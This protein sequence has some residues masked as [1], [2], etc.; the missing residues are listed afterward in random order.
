MEGVHQNRSFQRIGDTYVPM[1][2][3]P[4]KFVFITYRKEHI[5]YEE[6]IYNLAQLQDFAYALKFAVNDFYDVDSSIQPFANYGLQDSTVY[7]TPSNMTSYNCY[8]YALGRSSWCS[9][10]E[11]SGHGDMTQT[12]L[13]N[14]SIYELAEYVKDDLQSSTL[15]KKCVKITYTRPCTRNKTTLPWLQFLQYYSYH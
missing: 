6:I 8:A 10:G 9:P 13:K 14:K 3:S 12:T 5:Y 15:N 1:R 7:Q 2:R 11:L 4:K